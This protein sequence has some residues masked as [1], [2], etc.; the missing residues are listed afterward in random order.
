MRMN[1]YML[2]GIGS[3]NEALSGLADANNVLNF[4]AHEDVIALHYYQARVAIQELIGLIEGG[5]V[6]ES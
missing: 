5:R 1:E 2:S 3:L 4:D 6:H